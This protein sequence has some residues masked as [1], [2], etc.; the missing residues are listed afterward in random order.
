MRL[1]SVIYMTTSN[2]TVTLQNFIKIENLLEVKM[3][4][5]ITQFSNVNVL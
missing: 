4:S 5:L 3:Y 1:Q 2:I